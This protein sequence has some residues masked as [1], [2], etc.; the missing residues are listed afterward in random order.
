MSKIFVSGS[1]A[2]D[3]IMDYRGRFAR[4]INL[5]K[6]HAISISFAVPSINISYGGTA[7]NIAYNLSL[8][9]ERPYIIGSL[10]KDGSE[11][12]K[13]LK[14]KKIETKY[15]AQCKTRQTASA[16]M[17]TDLDDNQITGFVIGA[18]EK[19]HSLPLSG[20]NDLGIVSAEPSKAM[21]LAVKNYQKRDTPYVYDPG[22]AM[23]HQKGMDLKTGMSGAKVIIG[24]DYEIGY[25][26]K[27]ANFHPLN[28]QIV[29]T[30]LG[31]KG[32]VI[33]NMRK[34]IKISLVKAKRVVDPT[35][36]GDAYRSGLIK[37]LKM[38]YSLEKTGRLASLVASKAVEYKGTQEHKFSWGGIK[39]EYLK[40][41]GE[42]L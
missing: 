22:Q 38:G 13:Y 19:K 26:F 5:K 21:D 3:R 42:N 1:I 20:P 30:T 32:S 8:L 11:Y 4:D 6:V 35:G 18:L 10:G 25:L 39:K 7:G 36:A 28:S 33:Q 12:L 27:K 40:A 17:I 29:I 2:Y 23:T 15:I 37:G 34:K 14:K 31:A 24:N 16:Y 9:G 41:F